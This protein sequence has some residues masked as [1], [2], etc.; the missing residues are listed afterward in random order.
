[1]MAAN[2]TLRNNSGTVEDIIHQGFEIDGCQS[3]LYVMLKQLFFYKFFDFFCRWHS[4]M[5]RPCYNN[6]FQF[7]QHDNF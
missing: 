6:L 7:M 4:L 3:K 2:Q 5:N 1:M